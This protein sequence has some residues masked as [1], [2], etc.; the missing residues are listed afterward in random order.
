MLA[1]HEEG[2]TNTF[3]HAVQSPPPIQRNIA[4]QELRAVQERLA[5]QGVRSQDLASDT[6]YASSDRM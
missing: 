3:G 2:W 4:R 6:L 5:K 1:M